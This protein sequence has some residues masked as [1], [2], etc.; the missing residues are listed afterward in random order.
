MTVAILTRIT[1][2][3]DILLVQSRQTARIV[4]LD[5]IELDLVCKFAESP[6]RTKL[7]LNNPG[8][9]LTHHFSEVEPGAELYLSLAVSEAY[10][11]IKR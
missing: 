5:Y 4:T 11:N 9:S 8:F 2:V 10:A 7:Q 6:M 1:G 3:A